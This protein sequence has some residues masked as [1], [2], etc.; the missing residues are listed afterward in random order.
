MVA[1]VRNYKPTFKL[2]TYLDG[3]AFGRPLPDG[4]TTAP[5]GTPEKLCVF[6][7]RAAKRQ[8][9]FHPYDARYWGDPRPVDFLAGKCGD[10]DPDAVGTSRVRS[11]TAMRRIA[12]DES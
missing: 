2:K 9:L 1:P 6:E 4:P 7:E 10:L 8:Q 5:P 11:I 12:E 3:G